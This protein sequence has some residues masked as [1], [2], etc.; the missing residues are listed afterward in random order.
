MAQPNLLLDDIIN[1]TLLND[2]LPL[3]RLD[4]G[5]IRRYT[6]EESESVA[7]LDIDFKLVRVDPQ[8]LIT[9][10][11]YL[12]QTA[13]AANVFA[14]S[15]V[16][17]MQAP[18]KDP[19]LV[20]QNE[21]MLTKLFYKDVISGVATAF[22]ELPRYEDNGRAY[23]PEDV[24]TL[25]ERTYTFIAPARQDTT[26]RKK[27]VQAGAN[28]KYTFRCD[29]EFHKGA[30]RGYSIDEQKTKTIF[31]MEAKKPFV[32]PIEAWYQSSIDAS[33]AEGSSESLAPHSNVPQPPPPVIHG[34]RRA[35]PSAPGYTPSYQSFP[36]ASNSDIFVHAVN[37][38]TQ[39]T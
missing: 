26:K 6:H 13:R 39:S 30:R 32:I 2:H 11:K 24:Q 18:T 36:G 35:G 14:G 4:D 5:T 33:H 1:G 21:D 37:E 25:T 22:H 20:I 3:N 12:F 7:Q 34:S 23:Y 10:G 27:Q 16:S 9:E 31:N 15:S 17:Q 38:N 29:V 8:R 19:S 28:M